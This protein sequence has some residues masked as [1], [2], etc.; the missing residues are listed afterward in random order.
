M[1][2]LTVLEVKNA[3]VEE[4]GKRWRVLSDGHGLYLR[5]GRPPKERAGTAPKYWVSKLTF[6]G[7]RV[8]IGLGSA[9]EV[10]LAEARAENENLRFMAR[11]G[12][13]PRTRKSAPGAEGVPTFADAVDLY[14]KEKLHEFRNA[15]H[16]Q[17]WENTLR[18]YAT[19]PDSA[20][21]LGRMRV[22]EIE[23]DDVVRVL[24]PIWKTKTETASRVRGRVQNVLAWATAKKHRTGENPA[25]W[26][27]NLEFMLANPAKLKKVKNFEAM[28][29]Q[30]VPAFYRGL[31]KREGVAAMALRLAILTGMRQEAFRAAQ[32]SE[33][34]GDVWVIPG[35]RMK[36][37]R[38]DFRV[39]LSPE[40]LA[41]IVGV[42]SLSDTYLFPGLKSGRPV[43]DAAVS[44]VLK[45][46]KGY[47]AMTVHG[48]RTS[49][50]TWLQ[51]ATDCPDELA[52][53][54]LGHK[55]GTAVSRAYARSDVLHK[56]RDYLEQWANFLLASDK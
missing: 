34:E 35:D 7:Q 56:R 20:T 3:K 21:G 49:L 5:V 55:V 31:S 38:E 18:D 47:E 13:H 42:R 45:T 11:Q 39:P 37:L 23:P 25:R 10:T 52:E 16:R 28:P 4:P 51:D 33:I 54:T 2:F 41:V 6:K 26:K 53:M 32:W 14:L 22:D 43:T 40:A 27:G 8:E 36:G 1:G 19:K 24:K 17:Q 46:T 15:K 50:R 48:F 29:W 30:D 12:K 44:K 9:Y